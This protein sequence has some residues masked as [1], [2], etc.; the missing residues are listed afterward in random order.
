MNGARTPPSPAP[1]PHNEVHA[2][3][4]V[5]MDSPRGTYEQGIL[6]D[7]KGNATFLSDVMVLLKKLIEGTR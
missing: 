6:E 4:N 7:E 3:E 2:P 1:I 5:I